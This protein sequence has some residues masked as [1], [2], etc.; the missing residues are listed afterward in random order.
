M[1]DDSTALKCN[2]LG[3]FN[4]DRRMIPVNEVFYILDGLPS[5]VHVL[6]PE[7]L[8]KK[9]YVDMLNKWSHKVQG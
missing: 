4:G 5:T 9:T 1:Y 7:I 8:N 6:K 3:A 2:K